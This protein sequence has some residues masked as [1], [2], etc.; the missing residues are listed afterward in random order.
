MKYLLYIS[1]HHHCFEVSSGT[2]IDD[3]IVS[4]YRIQGINV[5]NTSSDKC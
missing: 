3:W 2:L 1:S 5:I 4:L